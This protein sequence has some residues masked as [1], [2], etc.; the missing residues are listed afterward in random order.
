LAFLTQNIANLYKRFHN[1]IGFQE[2]RQFFGPKIGKKSLKILIITLAP[3]F[4]FFSGEIFLFAKM[5]MEA[6][7]RRNLRPFA[8]G[9]FEC[10][11]FSRGSCVQGCQIFLSTIYQNGKNIPNGRKFY[12]MGI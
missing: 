4:R 6:L 12:Q 5:T 8:R 11:N 7:F 1:S 10:L 3:V 2:K 9:F